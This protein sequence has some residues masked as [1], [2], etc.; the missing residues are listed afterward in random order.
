MLSVELLARLRIGD[1]PGKKGVDPDALFEASKI[2]GIAS[3][4]GI[5]QGDEHN[6]T[7]DALDLS[8]A[9]WRGYAVP[10]TEGR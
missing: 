8:Y 3:R 7:I 2:L 9:G 1:R 5:L 6:R 10:E 4:G